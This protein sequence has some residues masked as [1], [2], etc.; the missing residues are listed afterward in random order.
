M[1]SIKEKLIGI[2]EDESKFK[3]DNELFHLPVWCFRMTSQKFIFHGNFLVHFYQEKEDELTQ[4]L[5]I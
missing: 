2:K 3:L 5:W 4:L 1:R